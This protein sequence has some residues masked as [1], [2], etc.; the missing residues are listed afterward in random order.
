MS[1]LLDILSSSL[2]SGSI[3][4]LGKQLGQDASTTR[5]AVN[6]ALPML[7]GALRKSTER[8]HGAGLARA[9]ETRHDGGIL[10]NLSGFLAQNDNSDG[11][12]ILGHVLGSKQDTA[13]TALQMASGVDKQQASS[14]L[15]TLA[16]IVLGALGKVSQGDGKGAADITRIL[17]KEAQ[18]IDERSPG[19]M[20]TLTSVLDADG[21]TDIGDLL[22]LGSKKMGGFFG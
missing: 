6:S 7:V 9:L 11:A 12:G 13:A 5:S 8:D 3:A 2:D 10:D 17:D 16:P 14:L 22:S 21:D 15:T 1:A 4:S 19:L 20:S 18:S